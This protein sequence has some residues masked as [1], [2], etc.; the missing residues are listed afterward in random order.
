MVKLLEHADVKFNVREVRYD[1]LEVTRR[2]F[3][4]DDT[5]GDVVFCSVIGD[6]VH[7]GTLCDY[8]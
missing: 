8:R 1:I 7:A 5:Q 4:S 6:V 2:Q 3:E